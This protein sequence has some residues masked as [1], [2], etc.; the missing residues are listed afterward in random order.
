M[1][2][3]VMDRDGKPLAG[4]R[5]S[6]YALEGSEARLARWLSKTPERAPLATVQADAKGNFSVEAPKEHAVALLRFDMK[7]YVP[8]ARTVERDEDTGAIALARGEAKEGRVTAGGKPVA[9]ATVIWSIGGATEVVATTDAEGRYSVPDP[10]KWANRLTIVHPDFALLDESSGILGS[11]SSKNLARTLVAGSALSGKV[12]AAD[13]KTGVARATVAIDGWPLATSGDDGSFTIAHAPAKWELLEARNSTNLGLRAKGDK[14][15]ALTVRMAAPA[16]ISGTLKDAKSNAPVAGA[17]VAVTRAGRFGG[18]LASVTTDAKGAFAINIAP[19]TYQLVASH[20]SYSFGVTQ[21]SVTAGQKV[22]KPLT[23]PRDARV[24]GSVLDEDKRPVAAANVLASAPEQGG[25]R[26]VMPMMMMRDVPPAFS[27]PDGRFV[28]RSTGDADLTV[29]A[30]K[31]GLPPGK[32]GPVFVAAGER[33]TGVIVTIPRGHEITG[34]VTDREGKPLSG[35]SVSAMEAEAGGGGMV[36]RRFISTMRTNEEELVRTG[37]DGT[38]SMRLKEG[39]YDFELKREGFAPKNVRGQNV[40]PA[41]KPL[42]VTLDPGAE[43][44]GRV[45]RNGVGIEGVNVGVMMPVNVFATTTGDGSFVLADLP[46]GQMM[47]NVSKIDEGIREMRTI[48][49]PTRDLVIEIPPGGRITGRV[50]DKATRQPVTSFQAGLSG[51]RGGGGMVMVGPPALR[52]FTSEDGSFT[53]ENVP[54][55]QGEVVV[56]APGYTTGRVTNLVVEEGKTI[57][58]VEV[59]MDTGVRVSGKV[60]GPDGSGVQ[61]VSVGLE[62]G[63]PIPGMRGIGGLQTD[64]ATTDA[65]GEY[66]LEAIEPGEKTLSFSHNKYLPLQK[67]VTLSGREARVDATLSSGLKINGTVTTEAGVPVADARVSA[68]SASAGG[69]GGRSATTD[70]NGNF[71]LDSM[72]PGRYTFVARKSGYAEGALRDFDIS[73]GAPVR[74]VLK[75]GATI[76]GRVTGL[77]DNDLQQVAVEARGS[78]GSAS[79]VVD[80]AGNYTIEGAPTGTV[81]VSAVTMRG[82]SSRKTTAPKSVQVEPGGRATVDLEF[83]SDTVVR[84]RVIRNGKPMA[85]AQVAFWPRGVAGSQSSVQTDDSGTYSVDGLEDGEYNVQVVD[86]A[87]FSPYRTTYTVRG[88]GTFD[89][90]IKAAELRGRVVDSSTG[91]PI[92]KARV[93]FRGS[94]PEDSLFSHAAETDASGAFTIASIAPGRYNATAEKQG[95]GSKV[96]EVTVTDS[97]EPVELK[98]AKD[99]GVT[100]RVVDARDNRLLNASVVVIDA[101]GRTVYD[102]TFRFGGTA[103]TLDLPVQAGQYRVTASANGYAAR[104]MTIMAPGQQTIGLTPGG[105]LLVRSKHATPMRGRLIDSSGQVYYRSAYR[106]DGTFPIEAKGFETT[107]RNIAPGVY[108]LQILGTTGDAVQASTQVTV[109]EGQIVGV[110]L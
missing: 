31:K 85:N 1:T 82:F 20:P 109:I 54:A 17:M 33:K 73:S 32:T 41:S 11:P 61:G 90:D 4:A 96:Q 76:T 86:M 69:F 53:L 103:E 18:E 57:E 9:G 89:I 65:S 100:L 19:G 5:V 39:T 23:A 2:G 21:V 15:G 79:G 68:S 16:T 12:V 93:Q 24:I 28:A 49:A 95:Y 99:P 108:T 107:L 106:G 10:A 98:L 3:T 72:T 75:S 104:T 66:T 29:R 71:S 26:M 25:G 62:S 87:R 42:E 97:A 91:A 84:G 110:D 83:R 59:A 70:A 77:S 88:S 63:S 8:S 94:A 105:T 52:S 51:T 48:A 67:K 35:V 64:G 38:F 92:E 56:Q 81:R 58:N 6:L 7:G 36:V 43:I 78:E 101:Q 60:T 46:P 30:V 55:G 74:V 50:V 80:A 22:H 14:A 13:G 45:V 27:G 44:T 102:D 47:V 34:R 37:S 40:S